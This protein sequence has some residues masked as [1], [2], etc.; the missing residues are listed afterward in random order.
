LYKWPI[1]TE[2][3]L[4]VIREMRFEIIMRYSFRN[5][6]IAKHVVNNCN[7]N[8]LVGEDLEDCGSRPAWVKT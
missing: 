2:K 1:N 6:K 5:K 4:N 8:Y 3:V 7:P